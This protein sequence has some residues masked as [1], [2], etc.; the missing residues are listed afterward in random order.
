MA[1]YTGPVCRLCRREKMKLFLKGPKCDSMKCPIERRPYPPGEHGRDR[2][3]ESEYQIQL[4][5][6]Q[7][8]RRIYGVLEKQFRNLYEEANRQQGITGENLLRMLELRLDNV[9]FR[10]GWGSSRAQ[11][12]QF[13]R[14]GHVT[15]NGKR[16]TIPSYRVRRDDVVALREK[17][18]NLIVVRHN[19]DTIDRQTP[20]WL[21][22]G[23]D[24]N[25]VTVRDLPMREHIDV[26]VREQLIVELYSK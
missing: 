20:P 2:P 7:K 13:V 10:A 4:R 18:R 11:A 5:E 25:D 15:V 24:G 21:D 26:P 1:R 19:I 12:R 22:R 6:K 9:V 14:H 16:V 17:S 23:G 8:A 3:R